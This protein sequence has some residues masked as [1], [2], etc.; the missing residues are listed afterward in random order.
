MTPQTKSPT[1]KLL[2]AIITTFGIGGAFILLGALFK[3]QHWVGASALLVA[4]LVIEAIAMLLI[5][6]YLVKMVTKPKVAA[7]LNQ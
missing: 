7:S 3:M 1:N 5:T 2:V 6:V 4:G